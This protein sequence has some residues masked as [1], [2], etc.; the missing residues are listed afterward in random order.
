MRRIG[1]I[2]LTQGER[3]AIEKA[4][5]I[6]R[7]RFPV[8]RIVLFGSKAR[9]DADPESDLDL[10][11]LTKRPLSWRERDEIT[12]ALFEVEMENDVVISTLVASLADWQEGAFS[13]LPIH[14]EISREG[15][16]A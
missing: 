3:Q 12:D 16:V 6:I 7:E 1:D 14:E 5:Q 13:V 15:V 4:C 8:E 2:Q 10:L 11:V 9:G